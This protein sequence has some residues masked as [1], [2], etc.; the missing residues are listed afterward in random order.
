[1][2]FPLYGW[3]IMKNNSRWILYSSSFGFGVHREEE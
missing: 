1:V 3:K 2:P